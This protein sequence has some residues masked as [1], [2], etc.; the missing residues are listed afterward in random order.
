MVDIPFFGSGFVLISS[1]SC[2]P[3]LEQGCFDDSTFVCAEHICFAKA[4]GEPT[5]LLYKLSEGSL[6][7]TPDFNVS[8]NVVEDNRY[9]ADEHSKSSISSTGKL[10]TRDRI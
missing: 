4:D 5:A 8:S 7:N 10:V 2:V 9:S 6:A 1:L 3:K